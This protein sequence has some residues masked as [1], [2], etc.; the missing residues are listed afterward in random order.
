MKPIRGVAQSG[1]T[2][3]AEVAV[4]NSQ[5]AKRE[6]TKLLIYLSNGSLTRCEQHLEVY[7]RTFLGQSL[8]VPGVTFAIFRVR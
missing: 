8:L 4:N 6:E 7:L 1:C 2:W 5:E 3:E